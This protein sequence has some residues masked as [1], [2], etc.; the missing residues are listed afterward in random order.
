MRLSC[1]LLM[2]IFRL[3]C[4]VSA[5]VISIFNNIHLHYNIVIGYYKFSFIINCC[6]TIII[7]QNRGE[8]FMWKKWKIVSA[9]ILLSI[10]MVACNR[11]KTGL[12]DYYSLKPIP[13]HRQT[14]N[15]RKYHLLFLPH[16]NPNYRKRA[17]QNHSTDDFKI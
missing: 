16:P 8:S 5:S 13:G 15:K 4:K 14:L 9:F 1:Y 12:I 2:I 11:A 17:I 7:L 10:F 6:K 3:R